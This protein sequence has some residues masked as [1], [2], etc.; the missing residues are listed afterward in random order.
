MNASDPA[1]GST[2]RVTGPPVRRHPRVAAAVMLAAAA[3]AGTAMA[4]SAPASA[5]PSQSATAPAGAAGQSATPATDA[6]FSIS[7]TMPATIA[8]ET[9]LSMKLSIDIGEGWSTGADRRRPGVMV[10]FDVPESVTLAGRVIESPRELARNEFLEEPFERAIPESGASI[11]FTLNRTPAPGETLGVNVVAYLQ[12]P[13]SE[14]RRFVRRRIDLPL[15]AGATA[16]ADTPATAS[17]W[18]RNGTLAIGQKA[19]AMVLSKADGSSV[20]LA[21]MLG[22]RPIV[23]TTYRAFW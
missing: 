15:T 11:D 7:A 6:P 17:T 2:A 22:E 21:E 13:E 16:T 19:P 4:G 8:G 14:G 10:Q 23:I 18:G 20:D 9:T 5:E 3:G 12:G 1:S